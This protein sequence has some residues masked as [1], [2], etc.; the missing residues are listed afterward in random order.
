MKKRLSFEKGGLAMAGKEP[1]V[2]SLE[3]SERRRR[4][5]VQRE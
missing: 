4:H 2:Q 3:G 1:S 5:E